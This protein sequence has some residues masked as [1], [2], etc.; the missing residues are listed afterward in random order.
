MILGLMPLVTSI[1]EAV[2]TGN[3]TIDLRNCAVWTS[4]FTL[5][6][7]ITLAGFFSIF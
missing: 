5:S 1:F 3:T 2:F 6:Y 7:N 4:A